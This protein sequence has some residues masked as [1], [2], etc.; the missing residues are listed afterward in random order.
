MRPGLLVLRGEGW[1]TSDGFDSFRSI[2]FFVT[3]AWKNI[4][5]WR[6]VA[7]GLRFAWAN[8][9]RAAAARPQAGPTLLTGRSQPR[10]QAKSG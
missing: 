4:M 6:C 1:P 10:V 8:A 5:E 2:S 9:M 3:D 7:N